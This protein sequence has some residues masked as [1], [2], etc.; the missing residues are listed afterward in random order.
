MTTTNMTAKASGNYTEDMI[1]DITA[2]Y[3]SAPLRAT[4]DALAA[5]HGKTVRSVIAKLSA[6]GIYQKPVA[7]TK[8][9]EPVVRKSEI[10][11]ELMAALGTDETLASLDKVSKTDLEALLSLVQGR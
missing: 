2:K 8:R 11:A 3:K 4:V 6:I 7:V 9:G 10:V 1:N 5:E